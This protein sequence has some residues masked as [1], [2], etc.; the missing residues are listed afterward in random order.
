MD[1]GFKYLGS[2]ALDFVFG[3]RD[4]DGFLLTLFFFFFGFFILLQYK[5]K[6][7][8]IQAHKGDKI[9]VHYRVSCLNLQ[10]AFSFMINLLIGKFIVTWENSNFPAIEDAVA[11][12]VCLLFQDSDCSSLY[13]FRCSC[14]IFCILVLIE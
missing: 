6:T 9:K 8:D 10:F 5:P 12:C 1:C 14:Y 13:V 7:C 11:V 3:F 2:V 4:D